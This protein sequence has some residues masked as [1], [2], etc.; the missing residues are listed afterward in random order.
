MLPMMVC[1]GRA[2]RANFDVVWITGELCVD[3]GGTIFSMDA[4]PRPSAP[5]DPAEYTWSVE[6]TAERY[7]RAGHARTIRRIQKY[8]ARGDLDCV[9]VETNFGERYLIAPASVDRH[10]AQIA[11]ALAAAGHDPA[12]PSARRVAAKLLNRKRPRPPTLQRARARPMQHSKIATWNTWKKKTHFFANK[13]RCCLN[14]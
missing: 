8:C 1:A 7:A 9:K 6:E 11:D 12:R 5:L 3:A 2:S 13:I 14:A 10:I 4:Q